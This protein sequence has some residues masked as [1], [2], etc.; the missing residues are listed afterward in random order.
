M[1][2]LQTVLGPRDPLFLGHS[3]I[4]EH[5]FVRPTPMARQNP[6]LCIDDLSRSLTELKAYQ[7]AG[8]DF[9][10]D[11][12]PVAAGRDAEVLR[13]LSESSGVSIAAVTGYHLLGFYPEDCWVHAM[14]EEGLYRLY[15]S[16]LEEGML[17][18]SGE[19][20]L[21]PIHP[22]AIRAGFVKAAIPEY[23]PVG[24]YAA[25]LRAAARAAADVGV[26][27]M[28]H[29][30]AGH[31]ASEAIALC[32]TLGLPPHRLVVCHADRQAS[33][34]T[35]HEVIAEAGAYLDYDTIARFKYHSDEEEV[36]LILHMLRCGHGGRILLA[37]DTTAGRLSS[38]GGSTGLTY[39]LDVFLPMLR[40]AG[41]GVRDLEFMTTK[42]CQALFS[43]A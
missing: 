39:L 8:G 35:P 25:L 4:H 31:R 15:R 19:S 36:A 5:I 17:P 37:L 2:Y 14:D 9:L 29:T 43:Q 34:Y 21:R 23:G 3:Q 12:Q 27:L 13:V 16:E 22:T 1:S 24:R 6:A 41:V 7:A 10:A 32:G 11:A 28:L 18:W 42:N 33:D 20:N 26:P 40:R 38:Y 30:E